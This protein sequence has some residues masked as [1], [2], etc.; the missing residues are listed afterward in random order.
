MAKGVDGLDDIADA[1]VESFNKERRE[2]VV[3]RMMNEPGSDIL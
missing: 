3:V 1:D 2:S